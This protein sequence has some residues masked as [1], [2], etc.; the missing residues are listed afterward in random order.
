MIL[1]LA[2][3]VESEKKKKVKDGL[4]NILQIMMRSEEL[5]LTH[6]GECV[7]SNQPQGVPRGDTP[8]S[9]GC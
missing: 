8:S 2:S 7:S 4:R 3:K 5:C 6:N 1:R 9:E